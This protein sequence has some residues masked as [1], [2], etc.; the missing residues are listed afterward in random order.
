M[1]RLALVLIGAMLV[2]NAHGENSESKIGYVKVTLKERQMYL[3]PQGQEIGQR[4]L[5]VLEARAV[6]DDVKIIQA[7]DRLYDLC[8]QEYR[9]TRKSTL[10]QEFHSDYVGIPLVIAQIVRDSSQIDPAQGRKILEQQEARWNDHR[11]VDILVQH[12]ESC[13]SRA[14]AIDYCERKIAEGK[15]EF[16]A[17]LERMKNRQTESESSPQ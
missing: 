4:Y 7:Y 8:D 16:I 9:A 6:G 14:N 1:S 5:A 10:F 12:I 17:P 11:I 13:E 3:T 2:L 15:K